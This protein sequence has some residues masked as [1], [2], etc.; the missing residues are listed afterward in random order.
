MTETERAQFEKLCMA[1]AECMKVA[2]TVGVTEDDIK[3]QVASMIATLCG[4]LR[5]ADLEWAV[6][7]LQDAAGVPRPEHPPAIH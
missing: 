4:N 5:G 3:D 1:L 2:R 6:K 7:L